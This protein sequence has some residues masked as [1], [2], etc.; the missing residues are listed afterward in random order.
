MW[1]EYP[2]DRLHRR[3]DDLDEIDSGDFGRCDCPRRLIRRSQRAVSLSG[4]GMGKVCKLKGDLDVEESSLAPLQH[5]VVDRDEQLLLVI[6]CLDVVDLDQRAEPGGQR[7][8]NE[9]LRQGGAGEAVGSEYQ[10]PHTA[11]ELRQ[12]DPLAGRGEDDLLDKLAD[13]FVVIGLLRNRPTSG[14]M[15]K[16]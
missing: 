10:T 1:K 11:A 3:I 4:P 15:A 6:L 9:G 16:G 5:G 2:Q 14:L 12:V 7:L 13:V 8:V